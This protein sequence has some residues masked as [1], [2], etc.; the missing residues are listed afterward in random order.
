MESTKTKI[1]LVSKWS[2]YSSFGGAS[3]KKILGFFTSKI[4]ADFFVFKQTDS[5]NY[6]YGVSEII[7]VTPLIKDRDF[8]K[9][10]DERVNFL[11]NEFRK[12]LEDSDVIQKKRDEVRNELE[13][14]E[15]IKI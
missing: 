9:F 10:K 11:K 6:T 8:K 4:D 12:S 3:S 1:W 15:S 13:A 14:L 7:P 5:N 2:V